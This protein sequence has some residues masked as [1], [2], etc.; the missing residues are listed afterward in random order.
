MNTP[1][2]EFRCPACNLYFI[3]DLGPQETK[4]CPLCAYPNPESIS[5][6]ANKQLCQECA[7]A[8]RPTKSPEEVKDEYYREM[9]VLLRADEPAAKPN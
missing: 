3:T 1:I 4:Y 6:T 9:L 5:I 2:N 8:E 7:G